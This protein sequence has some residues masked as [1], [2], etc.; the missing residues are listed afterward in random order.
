MW[1]VIHYYWQMIRYSVISSELKYMVFGYNKKYSISVCVYLILTH[2]MGWLWS[3]AIDLCLSIRPVSSHT[4]AIHRII[5]RISEL[6]TY[7]HVHFQYFAVSSESRKI[8]DMWSIL[9]H[10]N[11]EW[12]KVSMWDIFRMKKNSLL[13]YC[14][15]SMNTEKKNR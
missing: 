6:I 14:K 1:I 2:N 11:F 3:F 15:F 12:L 7:I 9:F 5:W 10:F 8:N 4:I 13:I